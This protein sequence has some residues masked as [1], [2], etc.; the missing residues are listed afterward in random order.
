[1]ETQKFR[2]PNLGTDWN[3]I[4]EIDIPLNCTKCHY[5]LN[6]AETTPGNVSMFNGACGHFETYPCVWSN[7]IIEEDVVYSYGATCSA[8]KSTKCCGY[9]PDAEN[10][11]GFTCYACRSGW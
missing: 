6:V 11:P 3:N 7:R 1:M 5:K 9:Y 8:N 10:R 2:C 4:V